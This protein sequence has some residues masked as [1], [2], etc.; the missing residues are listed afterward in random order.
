MERNRTAKPTQS[1]NAAMLTKGLTKSITPKIKLIIPDA[2]DQ[3]HK[4]M[5]FL[6]TTENATSIKPDNK[7]ARLKKSVSIKRAAFPKS[8]GKIPA[9][10]KT[11]P[12]IKGVYR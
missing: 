10:M 8:N 4:V 12:E 2:S 6:F 9:P 1:A 3:L 11:I 7:S 5:V